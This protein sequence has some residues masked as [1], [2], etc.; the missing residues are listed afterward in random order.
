MAQLNTPDPDLARLVLASAKYRRWRQRVESHGNKIL[1]LDVLSVVSRRPG[2]WYVALLDCLL[3]TPEGNRITRCLTLRGESVVVV[4]LLQCVEDRRYYTLLVEQRC[5]CDG[6]LHTA[7]PAGSVDD[8]EA[9]HLTA[10]R[11][12]AEETGLQV[13]ADELVAL[14]GAINLNASLSDDNVYFY[15]FRKEVSR[16]WLDSTDNLKGGIQAEGEHLRVRVYPLT[17]CLKMST[18]SALIGLVLASRVFGIPLS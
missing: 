12:L 2:S 14:S 1:R 10:C 8:A 4:P 6:D 5:I 17:E 15:G 13:A 18:T 16:D 7:F 9:F 11:E 3:L